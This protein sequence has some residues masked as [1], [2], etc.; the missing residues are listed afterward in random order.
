MPTLLDWLVQKY[1]TAKKQTLR[2]MLGDGRISINGRRAR[3]MK[4]AVGGSDKVVIGKLQQPAKASLNPLKL[5]HQDADIL[6]VHKPSGLL[7]STVARERRPTAIGIIRN[8]LA[9]H[10]PK[11]RPGIVH[12]LDRDAAGLLVFTKNNAAHH[13]LKKQFFHHTVDRE[14]LAVVH[15][16]V[17]PPKGIIESYLVELSDGAVRDTQNTS[18]GQKAITH[19]QVIRQL[20]KHAIVRVTLETGRK[21][22][23]RAHFAQRKNPVVGDAMYE[24]RQEP[25]TLLLL[26]AV[27]L[28]FDHPTTGQRMI[29][30]IPPPIEIQRAMTETPPA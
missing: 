9:D 13:A 29:F 17:T 28:A 27:K 2:D 20:P 25:G 24:G 30:E 19:Y 11:A 22:Q 14:Y 15:G 1:P 18:K 5:V 8:Y 4:E 21:H 23:I 12:R 6:V 3:S 7:T 16:A 10:D 26:C